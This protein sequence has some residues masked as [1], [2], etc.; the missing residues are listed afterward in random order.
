MAEAM[1]ESPNN[2]IDENELNS[3]TEKE[4]VEIFFFPDESNMKVKQQS[5]EAINLDTE[6]KSLEEEDNSL[7]VEEVLETKPPLI[8]STKDV[9]DTST[10]KSTPKKPKRKKVNTFK[11]SITIIIENNAL[12]LFKTL[13][14]VKHL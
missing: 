1:K 14:D 7:P 8:Q 10:P 11:D 12:Y 5:S 3:S 2:T 6:P 9:T 4:G 13:F